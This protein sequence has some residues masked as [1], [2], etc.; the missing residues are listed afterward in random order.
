MITSSRVTPSLTLL[1]LSMLLAG[2]AVSFDYQRRR[3]TRPV[4]TV[5]LPS[6][7]L[8]NRWRPRPSFVVEKL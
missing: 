2:C 4:A 5:D 7:K 3:R 8:Q 6:R 1:A